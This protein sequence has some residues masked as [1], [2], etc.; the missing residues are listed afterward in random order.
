MQTVSLAEAPLR[1]LFGAFQVINAVTDGDNNNDIE[2]IT[3]FTQGALLSFPA[4]LLL[5]KALATRPRHPMPSPGTANLLRLFNMGLHLRA[6][7][8]CAGL[9]DAMQQTMSVLTLGLQ[10]RAEA[11]QQSMVASA[12]GLANSA[13]MVTHIR[14]H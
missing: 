1:A 4:D 9:V 10:A 2:A 11:M 8:M 13:G 12:G 5:V 14:T 3:V 7:C 6:S